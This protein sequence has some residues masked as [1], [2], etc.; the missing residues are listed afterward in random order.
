M[1]G[2]PP[3]AVHREKRGSPEITDD[4]IFFVMRSFALQA[5]LLRILWIVRLRILRRIGVVVEAR[6]VVP[7][8]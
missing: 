3:S 5:N 8:P 7:K 4:L 6:I 2:Q 1:R